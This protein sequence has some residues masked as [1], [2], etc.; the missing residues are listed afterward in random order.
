MNHPPVTL[1]SAPTPLRTA[2]GCLLTCV[3]LNLELGIGAVIASE[4]G[5]MLA[6]AVASRG[7]NPAIGAGFLISWGLG[8]VVAVYPVLWIDRLRR[9]LTR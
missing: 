7:F 5:N 4:I 8:A 3:F 2:G 6:P 1:L 9:R